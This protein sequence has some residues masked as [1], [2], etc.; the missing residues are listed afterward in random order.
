MPL[1]GLLAYDLIG[2]VLRLLHVELAGHVL[3][4]A[5]GLLTLAGVGFALTARDRG[6]E[7][8]RDDMVEFR[9]VLAAHSFSWIG[10]QTMFVYMIAFVQFRFPTLDADAGGRVLSVSFLMLNAVG[11][12]MPAFV[13]EPLTRR[14]GQ[15]GVHST[16]LATM[17]AGFAGVYAFGSTP[18][19]VY[20]LMAVM[21]IGWAAIV[22]LP[23][24]IMSQR[25]DQSQIGLYMGVFNLSVVLPQLLVSLGVGTLVSRV[26]D[27]GVIF[28]IGATTLAISSL[29][30][31]FVRR[32][33]APHG[34]AA[35][36]PAVAH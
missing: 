12:A 3:E 10:V 15:I 20:A 19:I 9:K 14:F 25:V 35:I 30:W 6:V 17:A 7:F 24:A 13:L 31:L 16:C 34:A 32:S 23:F 18:A 2:M 8:V 33:T 4:I 22:S 21:G 27:K 28:L 5:C 11:A 29:A 1:W 36:A 26:A